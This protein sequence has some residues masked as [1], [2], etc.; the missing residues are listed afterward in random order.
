MSLEDELKNF[1][2]KKLDKP[3]EPQTNLKPQTG[4]ISTSTTV[5]QTQSNSSG[6]A[7]YNSMLEEMKKVT[8]KKV[9]K[10]EVPVAR[11]KMNHDERDFISNALSQ[12]INARRQQL[13]KN[14]ASE[15]SSCEWSD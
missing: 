8:L 2:L 10:A 5:S 6:G 15:T 3:A 13:T 1:K 7:G 14:N 12:A 11:P 9:E 4:N